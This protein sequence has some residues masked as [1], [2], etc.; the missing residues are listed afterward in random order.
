LQII[1]IYSLLKI[2]A[3]VITN[4]KTV[5]KMH[6]RALHFGFLSSK[7]MDLKYYNLDNFFK[8]WQGDNAPFDPPP[9]KTSFFSGNQ[10]LHKSQNVMLLN[11]G[12]PTD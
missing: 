7:K 2:A 4:K 3:E 9:L 1:L 12:Y 10:T 5:L 11:D 6:A 8:I